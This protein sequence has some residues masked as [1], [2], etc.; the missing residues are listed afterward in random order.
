[1]PQFGA[2]GG[3]RYQA[4]GIYGLIGNGNSRSI[5]ETLSFRDDLT[6]VHGT[7]RVQNGLRV[8]AFPA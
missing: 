4:S 7:T 8:V 6:K 3:D 5:Y 2:P 1:M